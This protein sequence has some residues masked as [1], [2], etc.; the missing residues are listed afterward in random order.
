MSK[1]ILLWSAWALLVTGLLSW[2]ANNPT[3][4]VGTLLAILLF[5]IP[6]AIA[7]RYEL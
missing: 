7:S 2:L 3:P 5:G 4:F 6:L 1:A